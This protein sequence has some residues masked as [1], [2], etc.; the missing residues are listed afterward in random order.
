[1]SSTY[2]DVLDFHNKYQVPLANKPTFL[3]EDALKFRIGFIQEELNELIKASEE[4]DMPEIIDALIDIVYVTHGF[5]QFAGISPEQWQA[6][7]DEVQGCNMNKIMVE[8]AADSKRGFKF[9]IKKPAGWVGP[10]HA[11]IIEKYLNGEF[12]S[13]ESPI[14]YFAVNET[15]NDIANNGT[16]ICYVEIGN[17]PRKKAE[18]FMKTYGEAVAITNSGKIIVL[19]M[20]HGVKQVILE[21]IPSNI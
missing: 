4:K 7:W 9:D 12:T 16:L 5:A 18:E 6:H 11:P 3:D 2:Q 19:P 1:M 14:K 13:E 20:K 21:V 17:L 15:N 8:S 10:D